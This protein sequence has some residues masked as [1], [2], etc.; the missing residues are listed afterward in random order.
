MII[1]AVFL[2]LAI[3]LC[4]CRTF[5]LGQGSVGTEASDSTEA[6]VSTERTFVALEMD[7]GADCIIRGEHSSEYPFWAQ[8]NM[9]S[10]TDES[11]KK[12]VTGTFLGQNYEGSYSNSRTTKYTTYQTDHYRFDG[13]WF[14]LNHSTGELVEFWNAVP[15]KKTD[16]VCTPE[17][18]L[19][20]AEEFASQYIKT[21][22]YVLEVDKA[23]SFRSYSYVRYI[24]GLKTAE[25]LY[26]SVSL[27]TGKILNFG[28]RM[29]HQF[30]DCDEELTAMIKELK[31]AAPSLIDEKLSRIYKDCEEYK[32][33]SVWLE[34]QYV[35]KLPDGEYGIVTIAE[36]SFEIRYPDGTVSTPE[37]LVY[38]LLKCE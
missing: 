16:T 36:A 5:D 28:A 15:E 35:C 20:I 29:L 12:T 32:G 19:R 10:H 4:S 23:S 1:F 24:G 9:D 22:E 31:E 17:E 27:Y 25:R 26:V 33:W 14:E 38:I 11:A 6:S 2:S 3:S 13:G 8:K 21:E 30:D 18:S 7:G 37:E 34:N